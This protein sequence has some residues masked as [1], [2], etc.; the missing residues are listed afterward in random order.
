LLTKATAVFGTQDEAEQW[1][2]RPAIGLN[3]K[4]PIDLLT[5]PAGVK[6][7]EDHLERLAYGV[8]A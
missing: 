1:F 5:T 6:I 7:V 4:R 3:Q 2:E 8:Y